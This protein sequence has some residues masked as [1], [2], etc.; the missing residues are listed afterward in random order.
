M[1][2]LR[3]RDPE[4]RKNFFSLYNDS[5]PKTLFARLQYIIQIQNWEPLGDVFWLK[6][7]LDLLLAILVV[8]KPIT[9]ASNSARVP[10]LVG[11][12]PPDASSTPMLV[13][14]PEVTEEAPLTF[15]SLVLKHAK[16]LSETS[17]L[18]VYVLSH[19][20]KY[21]RNCK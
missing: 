6:Q 5:L 3:A 7:G 17:K 12:D 21:L 1:L 20:P 18:Q 8:D 15:D 11:S 19:F 4:M 13:D 14:V 2:G 10:P 9:L 16:F